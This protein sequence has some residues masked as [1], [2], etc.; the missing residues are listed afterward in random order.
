LVGTVVK[1]RGIQKR[2]T[3]KE[4]ATGSKRASEK[5][6]KNNNPKEERICHETGG[7]LRGYLKDYQ[8]LRGHKGVLY[9]RFKAESLTRRN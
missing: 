4:G 5:K 6:K 7:V 2:E 1:T 3:L 9:A 8:G